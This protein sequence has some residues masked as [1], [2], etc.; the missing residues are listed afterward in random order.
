[1][2][3]MVKKYDIA[4]VGG[5][6][7]GL[8]CCLQINS[9]Y[10]V[11]LF[12]AT[13]RIGGR[14]ET[15]NMEGFNAEYGAMRFDPSRQP[16]L[17]K[18][19]QELNLKVERFH[20]YN[21][22]P[23]T[24]RQTIYKLNDDEKDLNALSLIKLAIRKILKKSEKELLSLNEEELE[25]IKCEG[26][27]NG[28]YLWKQGVWNLFSDVLSHDAIKYIINDG[29]FFHFVHEN[30]GI[31][32]IIT[33]IKM[34]QMSENLKGIKNGMER[35][36]DGMLKK[37][38]DKGIDVYKKH[39]LI[40]LKSSN[41][42]EI[43]LHFDNDKIFKADRVILAIP[44]RSLNFLKGLPES[45]KASLSSVVELPLSKCFFIVKDPW[46]EEDIT[47]LGQIPFPAREL[48]YQKIKGKGSIMVY[49]DRPYINFWAGYVNSQYHDKPEIN[50][51]KELAEKFAKLMHIDSRKILSYGIHDWGRAPYWA[52]LHNWKPGVQSGKVREKLE[53]FSLDE[54]INQKKNIHICGEAFSDYQ[55]FI[56]GS[57]RSANN[58]IQKYNINK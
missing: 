35:L 54:G 45:I 46:W 8:Y 38:T 56:E 24:Y 32:W 7:A 49:S 11:A 6:V 42:G 2:Q 58:V 22:P 10:K 9:E 44:Q 33:N 43:S 13:D 26:K 55:G 15:V 3:E 34:F 14:I 5:G 48:H 47:N 50:C 28:E 51:N 40:D 19:I 18:L 17:G 23:I 25:H 20:E 30:S 41:I 36:T 27:Y 39:N 1:M 16:I 57:L 21:T 53:A 31:D 29:S 12:E 4:V 37:I 52:A